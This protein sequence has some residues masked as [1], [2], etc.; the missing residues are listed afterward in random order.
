[1]ARIFLLSKLI[2][3]LVVMCKVIDLARTSVE[4]FVPDDTKAEW[5]SKLDT[6]KSAC[7]FIR[8]VNYADGVTGTTAPWGSK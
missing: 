2:S 4:P 8:A 5:N 7:D 6:I 3:T 1:M